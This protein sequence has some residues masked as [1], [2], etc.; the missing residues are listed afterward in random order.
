MVRVS[1][2]FVQLV[3]VF[4][5]RR[6]RGLEAR[7]VVRFFAK[8]WVL[9]SVNQIVIVLSSLLGSRMAV[10]ERSMISS[11]WSIANGGRVWLLSL[12]KATWAENGSGLLAEPLTLW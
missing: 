9:R 7:L 8:V 3:F 1:Q 10:S 6:F 2:C 12:A 4:L 11:G 5:V